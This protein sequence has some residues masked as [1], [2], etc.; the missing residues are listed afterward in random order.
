M[1]LNSLTTLEACTLDNPTCHDT[2]SYEANEW[3][4]LAIEIDWTD[5]KVTLIKG[6]DRKTKDFINTVTSINNFKIV[7]HSAT[8]YYDEIVFEKKLE[9]PPTLKPCIDFEYCNFDVNYRT[10][11]SDVI[12]KTQ[13]PLN[14][15]PQL[16]IFDICVDHF[17]T[18]TID[19]QASHTR[20]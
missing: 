19:I 20:R 17:K 18:K 2:W 12:R 6:S 9:I 15:E 10:I 14:L 11:C 8:T 1:E 5:N 13:Y 16:D 7:Q 3:Y 4:R